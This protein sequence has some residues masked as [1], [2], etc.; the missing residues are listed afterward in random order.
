MWEDRFYSNLSYYEL[1]NL[2]NV[3]NYNKF[4]ECEPIILTSLDFALHVTY[5]SFRDYI[6]HYGKILNSNI[7]AQVSAQQ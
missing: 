1:F 2:P 4:N 7:S 6:E 5:D 3:A